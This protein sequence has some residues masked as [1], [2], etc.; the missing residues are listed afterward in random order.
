MDTSKNFSEDLAKIISQAV[1]DKI[2]GSVE[3]YFEAGTVTQ[4]TQRIINK[5][6]RTQKK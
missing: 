6:K 2:Y 1:K 4:I 5:V 3:V